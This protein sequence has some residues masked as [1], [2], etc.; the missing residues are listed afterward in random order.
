ME[1]KRCQRRTQMD[2][3]F[4]LG[5]L[6]DFF[7]KSDLEVHGEKNEKIKTLL[8]LYRFLSKGNP[9]F[10]GFE[11]KALCWI[12]LGINAPGVSKHVYR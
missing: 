2:V 11:G 3:V 5:A 10:L 7:F 12:I 6:I 4:I 1:L 8:P 9:A